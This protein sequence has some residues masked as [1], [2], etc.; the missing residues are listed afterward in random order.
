MLIGKAGKD[1]LKQK[2]QI[3][4]VEKFREGEYNVLVSTRVGEE[5]LDISE[6]NLVVLYDNVP[7]SIRF[8]QRRGTNGKKGYWPPGCF[9]CKQDHR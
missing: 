1:G 4:A 8:V 5:G 6:V 3:E 7:S 2:K 9:N